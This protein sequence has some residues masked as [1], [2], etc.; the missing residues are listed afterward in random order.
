MLQP[1]PL[2]Q[3][4]DGVLGQ[5]VFFLS[6]ASA[7][8]SLALGLGVPGIVLFCFGVPILSAT[9]FYVKRKQLE[10]DLQASGAAHTGCCH[11]NDMGMH[12]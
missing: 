6:R 9:F 2:L 7:C 1:L 11:G 3:P 8:R 10:G 12:A 4:R 5:R